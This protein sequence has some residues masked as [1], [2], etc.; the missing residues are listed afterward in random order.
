MLSG[1]SS[2]AIKEVFAG[3]AFENCVQYN[4][5]YP[6]Y[7]NS[8]LNYP[9][10]DNSTALDSGKIIQ[11]CCDFPRC[12]SYSESACSGNPNV[13]CYKIGEMIVC[14]DVCIGIGNTPIT[15]NTTIGF[16]CLSDLNTVANYISFLP[17][18]DG[19]SGIA[20]LD[21]GYAIV[22]SCQTG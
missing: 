8:L 1:L 20:G 10:T 7:Y 13:I 3:Q 14:S 11:I 6:N 17:A 5:I 18:G 19:S 15:S 16:G 9:F 12:F 21:Q 22:Y 4:Y 2:W